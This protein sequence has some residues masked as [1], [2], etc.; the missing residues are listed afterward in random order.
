MDQLEEVTDLQACEDEGSEWGEIEEPDIDCISEFDP[1]EAVDIFP[2]GA[3]TDAEIEDL[4]KRTRG[5]NSARDDM[6]KKLRQTPINPNVSLGGYK[7]IPVQKMPSMQ[8][9]DYKTYKVSKDPLAAVKKEAK[10]TM[11][12]P[13]AVPL[14]QYMGL[15]ILASTDKNKLVSKLTSEA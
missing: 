1:E 15:T 3:D 12:K 11:H 14:N 8:R 10:D 5:T 7:S 4:G 9:K 6:V 2:I 13:V